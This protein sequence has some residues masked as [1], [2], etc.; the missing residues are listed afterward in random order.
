MAYVKLI[1]Y[2]SPPPLMVVGMPYPGSCRTNE[3]LTFL[4]PLLTCIQIAASATERQ[5]D[6][7]KSRSFPFVKLGLFFFKVFVR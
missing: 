5:L 3:K 6:Q 1:K 4:G 7:V 2:L